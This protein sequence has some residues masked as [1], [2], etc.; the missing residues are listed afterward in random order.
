MSLLH[1]NG[2]FC[3]LHIFYH[4]FRI[5]TLQHREKLILHVHSAT[6]CAVRCRLFKAA[7]DG[8]H[9]GILTICIGVN[10]DGV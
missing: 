6:N 3:Y 2:F 4:D 10:V 5:A 1:S 8:L 9:V 7:D